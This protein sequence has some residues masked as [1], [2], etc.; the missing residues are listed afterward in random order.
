MSLE[1]PLKDQLIPIYIKMVRKRYPVDLAFLCV[2][3]QDDLPKIQE[4]EEGV[5]PGTDMIYTEPLEK[6]EFSKPLK[7]VTPNEY[8]E[9]LRTIQLTRKLGGNIF[10]KIKVYFMFNK[11]NNLFFSFFKLIVI[12]LYNFRLLVIQI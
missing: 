1:I 11:T 7:K 10:L 9:K 8:I 3:T 5:K 2:P 12:R 4:S 6:S